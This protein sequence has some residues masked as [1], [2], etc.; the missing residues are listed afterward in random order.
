[1]ISTSG[2]S[3][4]TFAQRLLDL[5]RVRDIEGELAHRPVGVRM[6]QIARDH[7]LALRSEVP[8]QA[9]P[10]PARGAGDENAVGMES[11]DCPPRARR[12]RAEGD[13]VSDRS[14]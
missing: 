9:Q 12:R 6:L 11:K 8:R 2:G 7:A 5:R 3:S 14:R 1:L 4:A 10:D 13:L